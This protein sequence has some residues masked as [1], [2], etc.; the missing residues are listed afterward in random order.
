M[1]TDADEAIA[2][3]NPGS[4]RAL[5]ERKTE[6]P[7]PNGCPCASCTMPVASAKPGSAAMAAQ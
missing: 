4:C 6:P 7:P 1:A 2:R 3:L 5:E